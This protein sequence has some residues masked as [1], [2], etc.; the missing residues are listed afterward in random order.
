[1]VERNVAH[2]VEIR[3]VYD[4]WSFAVRTDGVVVNRWAM[5]DDPTRAEPGYERRYQATEKVLGDKPRGRM[6]SLVWD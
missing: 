6:D 5:R 1:M 2:I 4:G 3:G